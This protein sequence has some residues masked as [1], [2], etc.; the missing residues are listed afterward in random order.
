M[1]ANLK[2][3]MC[4]LGRGWQSLREPIRLISCVSR[5]SRLTVRGK[6]ETSTVGYQP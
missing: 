6:R 4:G 2:I 5:Y 3:A 1:S